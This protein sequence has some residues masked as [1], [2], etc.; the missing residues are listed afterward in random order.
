MRS[1]RHSCQILIKHDFS[2]QSF[3]KKKSPNIKFYEY[4]SSGSQ[5]VEPF[6]VARVTDKYSGFLRRLELCVLVS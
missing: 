4:P 3:L 6:T 1:T 2:R 5:V